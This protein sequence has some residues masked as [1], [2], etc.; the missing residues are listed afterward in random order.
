MLVNTLGYCVRE[1]WAS[2]RMRKMTHG[3]G[4]PISAMASH[5]AEQLSSY[6]AS[7]GGTVAYSET[8]NLRDGNGRILERTEVTATESHV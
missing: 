6:V 1:R 7:Y 3:P 8:I 2:R 5:W 4:E